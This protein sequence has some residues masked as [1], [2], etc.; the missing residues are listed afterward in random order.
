MRPSIELSFTEC[1]RL[2]ATK[3]VGRIAF[4]TDNGLRILPVNYVVD[5][6]RIVFRTAAYGVIARSLR[7]A[8]VAFEVDDLDDELRAGWSVLAVGP[9]ARIDDSAEVTR[10]QQG[11][12]PE[13]WAA[14]AR[15]LYF[16][17]P[18]KGLSGRRLGDQA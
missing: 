6:E 9:C 7:G 18:W 2:L 17:L 14:G 5:D 10:I 11:A 8:D 12:R 1:R 4:R 13:P 15:D 16:A 3:T